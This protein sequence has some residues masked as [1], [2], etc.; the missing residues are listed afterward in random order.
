MPDQLFP[1]LDISSTKKWVCFWFARLSVPNMC[2]P[3]I[4]YTMIAAFSICRRYF[5]FS[6]TEYEDK[7]L[8]SEL[9]RK[10]IPYLYTRSC[11]KKRG[12]GRRNLRTPNG[13]NQGLTLRSSIRGVQ[14]GPAH[15]SD[16]LEDILSEL[17]R[18]LEGLQRRNIQH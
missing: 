17:R 10:F 13:L 5:R 18:R 4:T 6:A 3:Y 16:T 11:L 7:S 1:I 9:K 15:H 12:T 2:M 8:P 14:P